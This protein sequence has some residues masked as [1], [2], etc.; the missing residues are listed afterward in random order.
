MINLENEHITMALKNTIIVFCSILFTLN[1]FSQSKNYAED[2]LVAQRL[3]IEELKSLESLNIVNYVWLFSDAGTIVL[4]FEEG[5]NIKAFKSHYKGEHSSK[6]TDLKLSKK[7]KSN[8]KKCMNMT[9]SDTTISYSNCNDF[10]HSFNRVVFFVS[11][12]QHY[13]KGNFTSDCLG[14]LDKNRIEGL[15]SIYKRH[16]LPI[17][18]GKMNGNAVEK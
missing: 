13:V 4:L 16:A 2:S 1:A 8:F 10:V 6:F 14:I 12:N 17:M 7:D 5:K 11:K 3:I 18:R 9:L 15:C